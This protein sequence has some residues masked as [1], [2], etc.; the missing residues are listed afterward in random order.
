MSDPSSLPREPGLPA[1]D[2][3][4]TDRVIARIKDA[5]RVVQ[6]RPGKGRRRRHTDS[7]ARAL[8]RVF[9][10]LGE[11]YRSYRRRTGEPVAPEVRDAALR[12]RR[13]LDL[14]SL[15]S[16]AATLERLDHDLVG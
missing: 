11:S 15:V 1:P 10:D 8:R 4:L 7:D 9:L 5:R 13:E 2:Q 16:V 6:G 14:M 3:R 12:F